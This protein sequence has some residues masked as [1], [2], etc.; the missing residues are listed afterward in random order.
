MHYSLK[1]L[2]RALKMHDSCLYAQETKLGRYDV[3]RRNAASC[4]PPHFVFSL[5]DTWGPQGA[6]C[7]WSVDIVL[8]RLRAHD[9]WR[10]EDFI[11]Q[12]LKDH[13]KREESEQRDFR[14]STESFLYDFA[15]QFQ[16][17]TNDVNTA[18]LNKVYPKGL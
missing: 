17:A 11:E 13:E 16:R 15:P 9:L 8:N 7:S 1:S 5:T 10:N 14:N 12:W 2:D 3:Y 18:S 6:P 4:A